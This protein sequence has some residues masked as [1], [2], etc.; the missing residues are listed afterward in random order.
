MKIV[1]KKPF[2]AHSFTFSAKILAISRGFVGSAF[3]LSD[4]EL[5]NVRETAEVDGEIITNKLLVQSGARFNV[6]C[7]MEMGATNGAAKNF[8]A[9]STHDAAAAASKIAGGKAEIRN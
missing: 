1:R 4:S 9:K 2:F 8:D 3:I 7:K 6:A 5:L